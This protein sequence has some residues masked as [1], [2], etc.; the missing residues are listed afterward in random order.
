MSPAEAVAA[1]LGRVSRQV[2]GKPEVVELAALCVLAGGHLLLEDV[3]GVGKTTLGNA[4]ARAHQTAAAVVHYERAL[5]LRPAADA[6]SNQGVA[7]AEPVQL[8]EATT[9]LRAALQ[10][11]PVL[12]EAH[13]Q[14]GRIHERAGCTSESE[15][16]F[17]ATLRQV[18]DHLGATAGLA[19]C[20][21]AAKISPPPRDISA[22]PSVSHQPRPTP[23][24]TSVT[25]SCCKDGPAKPSRFTKLRCVSAPTILGPARISASLASYCPDPRSPRSGRSAASNEMIFQQKRLRPQSSLPRCRHVAGGD[26]IPSKDDV[27]LGAARAFGLSPASRPSPRSCQPEVAGCGRRADA[28]REKVTRTQLVRLH[29]ALKAEGG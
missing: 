17:S 22:R 21:C 27:F 4:L 20:W 10:M 2:R 7:L 18:R 14:I 15:L 12:A 6:H 3:P 24:P 9:H 28:R 29:N 26:P 16:E 23:M 19:C 25:C 1:L 13:D 5:A 8:D 11:S